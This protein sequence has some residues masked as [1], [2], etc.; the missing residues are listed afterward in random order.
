MPVQ[1]RRAPS[2]CGGRKIL[3][4]LDYFSLLRTA[5]PVAFDPQEAARLEL[6][7]LQARR[8]AV[9]PQAHGRTVAEVAALTY[10]IT[11]AAPAMLD[12]GVARAEAMAYRDAR[13]QAMTE[14][15]WVAIESQLRAAHERLKAGVGGA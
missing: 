8:E 1:R 5:A 11:A 12:N 3:Y 9:S 15:G 2:C 4:L 13:G 7:W 10:G 14:E 6:D